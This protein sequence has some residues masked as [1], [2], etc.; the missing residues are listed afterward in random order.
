MTGTSG[1]DYF[2]ANGHPDTFVFAASFGHD[3]IQGF[4]ASGSAHDT[5]QFASSEFANFASVL[6][7]ASQVGV[8]VVIALGSDSLTLEEHAVEVPDFA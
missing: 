4:S 1:D 7:H 5:I 6:A 3:V 2:V 8:D